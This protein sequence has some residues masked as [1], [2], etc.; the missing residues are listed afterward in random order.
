MLLK[1]LAY[2]LL[3]DGKGGGVMVVVKGWMW[4]ECTYRIYDYLMTWGEAGNSSATGGFTGLDPLKQEDCLGL[5]VSVVLC[6]KDILGCCLLV[7]SWTLS[8]F[9]LP[10]YLFLSVLAVWIERG[11]C[12]MSVGLGYSSCEGGEVWCVIGKEKL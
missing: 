9:C 12:V 2:C 7:Y 1:G 6:T 8:I 3:E 10:S 4:G 5:A 11:G